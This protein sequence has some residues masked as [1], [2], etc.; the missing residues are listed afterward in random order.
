MNPNLK[1]SHHCSHRKQTLWGECIN[2]ECFFVLPMAV[3]VF[4][5]DADSW[6]AH[7]AR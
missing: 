6:I 1:H 7:S 4:L 2:A 3:G 5:C